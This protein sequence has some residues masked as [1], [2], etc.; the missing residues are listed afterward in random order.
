M[1]RHALHPTLS[2]SKEREKSSVKLFKPQEL[3]YCFKQKYSLKNF[4][5]N[6]TIS[7]G[8][9]VSVCF[10]FVFFVC[11]VLFVLSGS[12][13]F[14]FEIL[15][16]QSSPYWNIDVCACVCA[17]IHTYVMYRC[18]FTEILFCSFK[19]V[20]VSWAF[21][22]HCIFQY[23]HFSVAFGLPSLLRKVPL[24]ALPSSC[25]GLTVTVFGCA[26]ERKVSLHKLLV[27]WIRWFSVFWNNA[28]RSRSY[29]SIMC[30]EVVILN[31]VRGIRSLG[32]PSGVQFWVCVQ[33][34]SAYCYLFSSVLVKN[35]FSVK[36]CNWKMKLVSFFS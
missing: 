12:L 26:V 10:W 13:F 16:F 2:S 22:F 5:F 32:A 6:L 27:Q 24:D 20:N 25:I 11:F 35:L 9:P 4:F 23:F 7:G 3:L 28:E 8:V 29:S 1:G 31:S 36:T 30:G 14:I 15:I 21:A 33:S 18:I 34:S 17:H 19:T